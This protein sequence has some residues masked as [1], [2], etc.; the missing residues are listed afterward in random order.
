ML[1]NQRTLSDCLL[2]ERAEAWQKISNTRLSSQLLL[3]CL[4]VCLCVFLL[5]PNQRRQ[6]WSFIH[7][8]K[9]VVQ[10]RQDLC[11]VGSTI[12]QQKRMLRTRPLL[13][14]APST[15]PLHNK[16]IGALAATIPVCKTD[17]NACTVNQAGQSSVQ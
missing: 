6:T 5:V 16:I 12:A 3:V 1:T 9:N 8:A 14:C 13:R 2:A 15:V 7:Y 10:G 11:A 17:D 4:C